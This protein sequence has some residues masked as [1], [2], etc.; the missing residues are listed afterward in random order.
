MKASFLPRPSKMIRPAP[1]SEPESTGPSHV[2][3]QKFSPTWDMEP[4]APFT[5]AYS[6]FPQAPEANSML[7]A[8][9]EQFYRTK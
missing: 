7:S 4:D 1:V 5:P 6:P 9:L 8:D 3:P 2:L